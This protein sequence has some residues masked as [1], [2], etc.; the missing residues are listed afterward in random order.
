MI[1]LLL[2]SS[3]IILS[4]TDKKAAELK[5]FETAL[6]TAKG[7]VAMNE[8]K[9][10]VAD[11]LITAGN[12]L[13]T[14]A[15]A[16]DKVVAAERKKLDKEYSASLKPVTKLSTS[17]DKA[18]ATQ[19]KADMKTLTTKYKADSKALDT[20]LSAAV[21]KSNSGEAL[22]TK[23]KAGKANAKDA[24]KTSKES[25]NLAQKNFDAASGANQKAPVKDNKKK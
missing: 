13:V 23:G 6:N 8:R 19:A 15:S 21:K 14:E 25:L 2:F 17:K 24:L 22:I 3:S 18:V 5:K 7:K 12:N 20:R 4:Q 9:M 1:S 10:V 16:E 11:S